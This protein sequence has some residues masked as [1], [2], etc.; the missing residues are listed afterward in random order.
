MVELYLTS[1]V[2]YQEL[3]LSVGI[4]NPP[5]ILN[6]VNDY[7]IAGPDALRE[8]CK[9]RKAIMPKPNCLDNSVMEN[10]FG[11]LKQE[12]YYGQSYYSFDE[13]KSAIEQYIKYYNKKRTKQK[14]GYLSPVEYRLKY[15]AA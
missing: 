5:L 13:L 11:I 7:R 4:N 1:E 15:Q 14:L 6:W 8:K 12:I 2:S 3:A 9:G 10:F